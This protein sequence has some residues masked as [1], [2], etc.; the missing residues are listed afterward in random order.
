MKLNELFDMNRRSGEAGANNAGARH[1]TDTKSPVR[2]GIWVL[3]V[4]FGGFLLWAAFAPLDEGVPCQGVVSISTKRKVVQHLHGGTVVAVHV[5]EGQ[6]VMKG[7]PLLRLDDQI[8]KARYAEVHQHY[9]G[10]RASEARLRAERRGVSAMHLHPDLTSDID[11]YLVADLVGAQQDLLDARMSIMRL[12]KQ[13]RVA[14]AGLVKEGFIPLV[15][16]RELD[17][18]IAR[19]RAEAA[20]ELGNVLNEVQSDAEK[21]KA[22]AQE[23]SETVVRSPSDGQVVGLQVQ[24]VGAVIQ[25][26]QQ[27]MDIVPF[28]EALIIEAKVPPHL[29]D[30]VHAGLVA[31]VQFASFAHSPLLIV[32]GRVASVSGDLLT[33]APSGAQPAQSYYL[34]RIA[35]TQEGMRR[36]AGKKMQAGMPV[37]AIILTGERS[38]LTYILHPLLKRMSASLKEE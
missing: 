30:M 23:L 17:I 12:L 15:Q 10:L 27:L 18:K 9:L 5:Q 16:L 31:N 4:G 32:P 1:H 2:L 34:I 29:I 28:N 33:D 20:T 7:E 35:V 22:L 24:T 38:L 37:Q 11:Q 36:L 8:A 19:L 6:R 13:E 3:L 25:P 14:M 21:S 26:G